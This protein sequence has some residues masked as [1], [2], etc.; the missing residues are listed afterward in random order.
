MILLDFPSR[1]AAFVSQCRCHPDGWRFASVAGGDETLYGSCFAVMTLH[2]I[3]VLSMFSADALRAW[4]D[5]INAW[6]DPKT[7]LFVGPEIASQ[8]LE[9]PKHTREHLLHHLTAHALPALHLLGARPRY[10]L[11]FA[12]QFIDLAYLQHWL[13]ARDWR[14]AWLEGNNLL[15]IGQFLIYLR[16]FEQVEVAERALDL[17]F[18]WLDREVDPATGLWGTNGYC[19]SAWALYGGYHQLLVYHYEQHPIRSPER[20][21][22]IA[23]SLQHP[24]GG[25]CLSGGGGA[26]EDVDAVDILVNMYERANYKRPQIRRALRRALSSILDKQLS[27]GG[28]AYRLNE[29]FTHMGIRRTASAPNSSSMFSTWFRLHTLALIAQILTDEPI[30]ELDWQFNDVLSMGWH[31]L[32]YRAKITRHDRFAELCRYN[33][34]DLRHEGQGYSWRLSHSIRQARMFSSRARRRIWETVRATVGW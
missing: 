33:W 12:H 28:F 19:P 32:G 30:A 22:D 14:D 31:Q 10:R 25:F 27:D 6:Q 4:A 34:D 3:G 9:S 21:V 11:V 1:V 5:Y 17:Y 26:C 18:D 23:L 15:F 13:E 24:D 29:P 2:Y 7:G 20:L 16:D 8:E